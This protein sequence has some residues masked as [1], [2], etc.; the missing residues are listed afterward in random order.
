MVSSAD[1]LRLLSPRLVLQGSG[2]LNAL[3]NV[4]PDTL[5]EG[6]LC[7]VVDE[8]AL[9]RLAKFSTATVAPPAV[10]ATIRGAAVPGR[11]RLAASVGATGPAGTTGPTGAAGAA[12]ADGATG[13]TGDF[14]PLSTVLFV[15]AG[16]AVA[17]PDQTGSIAKP[18][19]TIT[20]ALAATGAAAEFTIVVA[21]GD[22]SAEAA[23]AW[24]NVRYF[25]ALGAVFM[26]EVNGDT[27]LFFGRFFMGVVT[28]SGSVF[29]I[30]ALPLNGATAPNIELL[31]SQGSGVFT[32]DV[33]ADFYSYRRTIAFGVT[34]F[35][36]TIA[37]YDG[38]DGAFYEATALGSAG[39]NA[40]TNFVPVAGVNFAEREGTPFWVF[41]PAAAVSTYQVGSA[42]RWKVTLIA[43]V[44]PAAAPIAAAGLAMG[45]DFSGDLIGTAPT[46][47]AGG[48]QLVEVTTDDRVN[49]V[50]ERI[51]EALALTDTIQPCF[52]YADTEDVDIDRLT[53][54][55]SPA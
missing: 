36:G 4:I 54:T 35:P 50:C 42:S 51:V 25:Y 43:S 27:G 11:W 30:D 37:V 16:T 48:Q 7:Y 44:A 13:P 31:G 53:I 19:S 34:S 33:T 1:D 45:I 5:P 38:P 39:T 32:G 12:G 10:I 55:V 22:Y 14:A 17:A 15:D 20:A 2:N 28:C 47:G 52:A 6:C 41:D 46:P 24:T 23:L 40:T 9:Y 8:A 18:F 21:Q 3:E 26:P 29:F 49:I